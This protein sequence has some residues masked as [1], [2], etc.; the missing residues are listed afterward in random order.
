MKR[1]G[2]LSSGQQ[3]GYG[4]LMSIDAHTHH[5]A[6]ITMPFSVEAAKRYD[7]R[8]YAIA[9]WRTTQPDSIVGTQEAPVAVSG[10]DEEDFVGLRF[11]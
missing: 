10:A 2:S 4:F 6:D 5:S 8:K 3:L 1:I 9:R 11:R 7:E